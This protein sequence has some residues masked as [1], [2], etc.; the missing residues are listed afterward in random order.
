MVRVDGIAHRTLGVGIPGRMCGWSVFIMLGPQRTYGDHTQLGIWNGTANSGGIRM[1]RSSLP[2][3]NGNMEAS[4]SPMSF[5]TVANGRCGTLPVQ[6][7][8]TILFTAIPRVR[9]DAL[10][11]A[12]TRYSLRLK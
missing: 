9:T 6:T 7:T 3:R 12:N 4:T 5:I 10:T 1:N 11:G 2:A 8:K